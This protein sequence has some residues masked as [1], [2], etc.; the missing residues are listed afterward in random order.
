MSQQN[1]KARP[2][3]VDFICK[4]YVGRR[5]RAILDRRCLLLAFIA[6]MLPTRKRLQPL[7]ELACMTALR[8]KPDLTTV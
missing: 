7:F 5:G 2:G 4:F 8:D 1:R 6:N 3:R